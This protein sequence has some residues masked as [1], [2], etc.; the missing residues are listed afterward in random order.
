MVR[1]RS[2]VWHAVLR[3][4]IVDADPSRAALVAEGLRAGGSVDVLTLESTANLLRNLVAFDPHVVIIDLDDP[5]RDVLE[6]MFEIGRVVQRPVAMFVD[7]ANEGD[8]ERAI[9]AGVSAYVVDGLRPARVRPIVNAAIT[10]YHAFARLRSELHETRGALADR[11]DVDR[12][13]AMLMTRRGMDED[14]AYRA[15]RDRAMS[16]RKRIGDVARDLLEAARFLGGDAGEQAKGDGEG[17][18]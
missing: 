11:R 5:G 3:V 6:Q 1:M 16:E 2:G 15:L 8:V 7:R 13:K 12:A 17:G 9:E 10:R 4:A 18:E 14:A